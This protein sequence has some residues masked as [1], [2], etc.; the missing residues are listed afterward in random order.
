MEASEQIERFKDFIESEYSIELNEVVRT[1]KNSLLLSF[2]RLSEFD[3]EFRYG[4]SQN[5]K[6]HK[7]ATSVL[8]G[9]AIDYTA[10]GEFITF[11]GYDD[12]VAIQLSLRFK[13]MEPLHRG[14][15][16]GGF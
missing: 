15:I 3:V 12:P 11:D 9:V 5:Q 10:I 6:I 16:E 7:I 8:E 4:D 13:E 2:K 1:G 14:M